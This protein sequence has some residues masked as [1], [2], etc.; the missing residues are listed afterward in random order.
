M[1]A[2]YFASLLAA[3]AFVLVQYR[4][5]REREREGCFQ[6]FLTNNWMG[7]VVFAGIALDLLFRIRIFN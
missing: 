6:A 1:G 7:A 4:L 3:A 2:I 5:I